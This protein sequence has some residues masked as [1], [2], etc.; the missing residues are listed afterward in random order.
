MIEPN[1]FYLIIS[2]KHGSAESAMF[3]KA[4]DCGYTPYMLGA[5]LYSEQEVQSNPDYYNDGIDAVAIPFTPE[6]FK[7]VGFNTSY[8]EQAIEQFFQKTKVNEKTK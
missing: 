8:D 3:W 7:K 2:L 5:G 6:A 4:N 1:M